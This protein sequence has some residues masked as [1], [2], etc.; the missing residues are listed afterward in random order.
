M[1]RD[2]EGY[3][4]SLRRVYL[5]HSFGLYSRLSRRLWVPLVV[6]SLMCLI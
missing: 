5:P 2:M 6:S 4:N 1:H 3:R